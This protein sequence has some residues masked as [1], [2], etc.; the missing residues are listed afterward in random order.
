MPAASSEPPRPFSPYEVAA[1]DAAILA[2]VGR[3]RLAVWAGEGS[4]AAA[5][6]PDGIWLDRFDQDARHWIAVDASGALVAA[7]RMTI[8]ATL[9]EAPDGYVWTDAGR[10]LAGPIANISKLVV[11]ASARGR[12][13]GLALSEARIAA[14]R[15]A[16]VRTMTVTSSVAN[17]RLLDRLGFRDTGLRCR[18]P[19]R[20]GTEF[21]ALELELGHE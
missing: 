19:D 2:A 18:F 15:V 8:H 7:A 20:P 9:A 6:F 13:L 17:A 5:L 14:A 16:G 4:V 10:S 1:A 3:L 12:G 11:A 21:L